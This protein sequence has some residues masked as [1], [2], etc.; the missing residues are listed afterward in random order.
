MNQT[1]S[2]LQQSQR[3]VIYVLRLEAKRYYVG[4]TGD[5]ERRLNQHTSGQGAV[6][7]ERYPPVELAASSDPVA[8]WKELEREVTLRVMAKYGWSRV[9]GG[10]WTQRELGSPPSD[11]EDRE[12]EV[13][14]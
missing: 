9:R 11:L 2:A 5:L 7:T 6:W 12:Q 3:K 8:N 10:P 1:I 13:T 4:A 14:G